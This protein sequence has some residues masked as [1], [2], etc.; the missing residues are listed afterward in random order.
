MSAS[1]TTAAAILKTQYSPDVVMWLSYKDNPEIATVDRNEN[2]GGD[3][4]MLALQNEVPQGGSAGGFAQA[5]TNE[6]AGSYKRFQLTRHNDYAVARIDGE[7][8]Q[9]AQSN[10]YA[11]VELFTRE[12]DGA[13]HTNKRS[14]AISFF[15]DGTGARGQVLNVNVATNAIS[16]TQ[17]ADIT[18]FG[19]NMPLQ[20]ANVAG[21][22]LR[23]SG[24]VAVV[25]KIDR[26]NGLLTFTDI[27]ANVVSGAVNGDF[28]L[29]AGDNNNVLNGMTAMIPKVNVTNTLFDGLDR[30]VDPVRLAGQYYNASG[31][32]FR[33]A[34]IET[35]GRA[36]VEGAD[37]DT[38]WMHTRDKS[39]LVQEME[40]KSIYAKVV[41]VPVPGSDQTIGFDTLEAEFDGEKVRI[42]SSI[43]VPRGDFFL[44][45]W[46][47]M[48]LY[49]LGPAPQIIDY[50]SLEAL[51]VYNADSFEVRIVSRGDFGCRAPG[52]WVH[53][54]SLGQ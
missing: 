6:F 52:Y 41:E 42:M 15:R 35:L 19:L 28:L 2:F 24:S 49:S 32:S 3:F 11:M 53:G 26:L 51:R 48:G 44:G 7:A 36:K 30:S 40:G 1:T 21:G 54:F 10:T 33:G 12:V 18:N 39:I 22:T 17:V 43:N 34:I 29:R 38:V 27:L 8:W 45:E 4:F 9:A 16:L 20:V 31:Q 47:T 13:I 50:D 5:Q 37:A 14:L 25:Q 23:N 46:D